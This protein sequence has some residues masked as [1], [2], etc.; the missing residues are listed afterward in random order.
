MKL[1]IGVMKGVTREVIDSLKN[2][3]GKTA[4]ESS[5]S[6]SGS[7]RKVVEAVGNAARNAIGKPTNNKT[8]DDALSSANFSRL[9]AKDIEEEK[10]KGYKKGGYVKAADGCAKKGKTKGRMV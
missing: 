7:I 9:T 3:K 6:V 1:P 5:P 10:R 4:V 8:V 2:V